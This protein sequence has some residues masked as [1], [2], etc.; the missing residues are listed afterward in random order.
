M[1]KGFFKGIHKITAITCVAA[2]SMSLLAGCN[3][4][5]EAKKE[6]E[7]KAVEVYLDSSKPTE[8]RVADL[9]SKMTVEQKISQMIMAKEM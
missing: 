3:A 1:I 9:M 5:D 7:K 4:Q 6:E 2:L 8:E